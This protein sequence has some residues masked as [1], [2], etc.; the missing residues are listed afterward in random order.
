MK[1]IF[2][3]SVFAVTIGVSAFAQAVLPTTWGFTTTTLP[4]GWAGLSPTTNYYAASGNPAPSAKFAL[5]G[6]MMTIDFTTL[7]GNLTYDIKANTA[8]GA[9]YAGTFLVEESAN[10]TTWTTLHSF[11]TMGNAAYVLT[12]DIPLSTTRHIRFNFQAKGTG[13]VSIDNVTIAAGVS[14]AAQ[15]AVKQGTTNI[16][17]GGT[18]TLGSPVSTL[19]PTTFTVLNTGTVSALDVT[20]AN[21][22]GTA[23]A[24][25]S[26]STAMPINVAASSTANLVVNFTPSASGTRNAILTL[27][28]NDPTANPYIINLN[29]IGGTLATEPTGQA[30][31]MTFPVVKSFHIKGQYT[32]AASAPDGYLLLRKT[33]SAIT[34][35]PV[36]GVVYQRGDMIGASKV[37]Y[38]ST[39]T[40]FFPNDIVANTN[41]Y[42]AVFSYNGVGTY[43]NYLT[44]APLTGNIT[45]SGTM[46]AAG[47]YSAI[48]T[49][50]ST[51]VTD[52][53]AKINP[54]SLQYY[55]SYGPLM[56][57][58]FYTRDTTANQ[59]VITCVYSG[60]NTV[61]TEP[62]DWTAQDYSR[63][64]TYCKSWMPTVND[65]NFQNMPEYNDYHMLTPTDQT[66]VNA[67]RSNLP[68]GI[69]VGTPSY[70]FLGCKIG[71][72]AAGKNVFEPRDSDKGDAARCMLYECIAYTGVANSSPAGT[73][74]C[75][76]GGSWSLP[77]TISNSITYDQDQN[78]LKQWNTQDP[79]DN[80]EISRNDYVDSLQGNRN[81]FIDHPEY[82]CYIDFTTM[83]LTTCGS[84]AGINENKNVDQITIYPNPNNGSFM[85]NYTS[86]ANQTVNLKLYD[87]IGRVVYSNEIKVSN[88]FNPIEMNIQ[89]LNSGIYLFEFT[90]EQGKQTQKFIIE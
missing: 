50:N 61:Y 8:T 68:L 24:D 4:T 67:H 33:G 51:F 81:P 11:T 29:G 82:V 76:H 56:A 43:R 15:M 13:N 39:A 87:R 5:T 19:L 62:F 21:I 35:V 74:G 20:A 86:K 7:P 1:K 70:T 23:A 83:T 41:Y 30:T 28:N 22:T 38:S 34:D 32:A 63:E 17:N 77:T 65:A 89:N 85:L 42:F 54:H 2:L 40:G 26:V 48:S 25:F 71:L 6:D 36:D 53:H 84:G 18:Y 69:V 45:S 3:S 12:T 16:L 37:V 14:T 9:T 10:G 73:P 27:T 59:R 52:L 75:V 72:N 90:T 49:A 66:Q 78:V 31:S 79:P 64:H 57:A 44:T 80:F 55:S 46:Q 58:G 47:Y 60:E 88:G